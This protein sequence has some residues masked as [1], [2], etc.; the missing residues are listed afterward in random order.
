MKDSEMGK[1]RFS[2]FYL[3]KYLR[4]IYEEKIK[5]KKGRNE[6]LFF[7]NNYLFFNSQVVYVNCWK[8]VHLFPAITNKRN[9]FVA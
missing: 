7:K 9:C 8:I 1:S 4:G 2:T 5:E 6:K 3:N